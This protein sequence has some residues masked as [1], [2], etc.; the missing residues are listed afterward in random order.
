MERQQL[1]LYPVVPHLHRCV[2]THLRALC[3]MPLQL[4][5]GGGAALHFETPGPPSLLFLSL[6]RALSLSIL[7]NAHTPHAPCHSP[8]AAADE[9]GCGRFPKPGEPRAKRVRT[10]KPA[11]GKVCNQS[12][13]DP[14]THARACASLGAGSLGPVAAHGAC[15]WCCIVGH[16]CSESQRCRGPR[17]HTRSW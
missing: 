4:A 5:F 8:H 3:S 2:Q 13:N 6:A 16:T 17:D 15:A 11:P 12:D 1:G 7:P 14:T 10:A 9:H